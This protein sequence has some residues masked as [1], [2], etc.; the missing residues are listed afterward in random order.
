MKPFQDAEIVE[1]YQRK[2]QI[3]PRN[4]W[5]FSACAHTMRLTFAG[6]SP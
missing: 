6:Q 4:P 1:I 5:L 2:I 3:N